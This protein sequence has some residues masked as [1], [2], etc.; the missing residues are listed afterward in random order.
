MKYGVQIRRDDRV[1]WAYSVKHRIE[2][3]T[4]MED[5]ALFDRKES[6]I[7]AM[8]PLREAYEFEYDC[9]LD[10]VAIEFRVA[11]VIDVPRPPKSKGYRLYYV[12][13]RFHKEKRYFRGS[14]AGK[15]NRYYA[16]DIAVN[17]TVFK[18][19]EELEKRLITLWEEVVTQ[20]ECCL[21]DVEYHENEVKWRNDGHYKEMHKHHLGSVKTTLK[22]YEML[23]DVLVNGEMFIEEVN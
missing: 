3:T 2:E 20:I 12:D 22:N 8:K 16:T 15:D 19:E 7:K 9:Q 18:S 10:I 11:D 13:D 17:A 4:H 21:I 5:M 14:R 23:R 1:T 6:A